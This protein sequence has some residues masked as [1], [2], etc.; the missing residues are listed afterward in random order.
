MTAILNRISELLLRLAGLT[1]LAA[2]RRERRALG[3]M[4]PELPT[5]AD[6]AKETPS[7]RE[8]RITEALVT[9]RTMTLADISLARLRPHDPLRSQEAIL[10]HRLRMINEALAY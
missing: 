5:K 9:M 10:T 7:Q 8:L 1:V 6:E 2:M 3:A 4:F